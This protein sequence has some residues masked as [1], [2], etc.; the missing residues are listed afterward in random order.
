MATVVEVQALLR[1]S[2]LCN[3]GNLGSSNEELQK[4]E[5]VRGAKSSFLICY[6]GKGSIHRRSNKSQMAFCIHIHQELHG[7]SSCA[8]APNALPERV[9]GEKLSTYWADK[10]DVAQQKWK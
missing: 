3:L 7:W 5:G 2:T 10:G 1:M 6:M 4:M 8:E 9:R